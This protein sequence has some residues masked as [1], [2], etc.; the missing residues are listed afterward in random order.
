MEAMWNFRTGEVYLVHLLCQTVRT[1]ACAAHLARETAIQKMMWTEDSWLRMADGSNFA[2]LEVPK[3][4]S[5]GS[6]R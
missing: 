3:K 2:K 6:I 1:G 4:P 5:A